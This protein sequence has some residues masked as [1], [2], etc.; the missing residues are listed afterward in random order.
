M[1][2]TAIAK[3]KKYPQN[4]CF[5]KIGLVHSLIG[6]VSDETQHIFRR[7][8]YKDCKLYRLLSKGEIAMVVT[9]Y[10]LKDIRVFELKGRLDING[11]E[12]LD[13]TLHNTIGEGINKIIMDMGHVEYL[14][15][16]SLHTLAEIRSQNQEAGGDLRLARLNPIVQ[17]VFDMVGFRRFF[18]NYS[19]IDTAA[20]DF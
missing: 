8:E 17:R 16:R 18:R 1:L 10:D 14:N 11:A 2:S 9:Q 19:S 20:L 6:E 13:A 4:W 5:S 3:S 7:I 15:S 12:Q